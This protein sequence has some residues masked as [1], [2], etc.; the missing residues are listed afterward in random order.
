MLTD[1]KRLYEGMFLVDSSDA[2][3]DWDGIMSVI[4]RILERVDADI[5]SLR[6]WDERK[7]AYKI[8]GKSR[9]TYIL[10]YFNVPA[11]RVHEIER[12]VQLSERLMRVLILRADHISEETISRE[13]SAA[14]AGEEQTGSEEQK[15]GP[16]LTVQA[17]KPEEAG[18][19]SEEAETETIEAQEEKREEGKSEAQ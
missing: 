6:K 17:D 11:P 5:L 1:S 18:G 4:R 16:E 3:S 8:K 9:G 14:E 19:I 10:S 2:A 13:E 15:Q 12:E 7:L